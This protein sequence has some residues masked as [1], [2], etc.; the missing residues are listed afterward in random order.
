MP[1]GDFRPVPKPGQAKKTKK[2]NGYKDKPKRLCYYC[3]TAGAE[4]HEVFGGANRQISINHGFQ[5]DL[6]SECH[7]NMH[8]PPDKEWMRRRNYWK[9]F[10]QK[11]YEEE[12]VSKGISKINARQLWLKLIGKNYLGGRIGKKEIT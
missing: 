1:I 9:R 4:R 8:N 3:K 11:K 7:R 12:L 6:C 10:F 5:I 2:V